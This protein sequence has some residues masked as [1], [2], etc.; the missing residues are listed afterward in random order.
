MKILQLTPYAMDRPGGVQTHVRDLSNWLR[1]RGHDVRI[2]APP[3]A[4]PVTGI[5]G[6]I[7][8]GTVRNIA[9]HGTK[10]E[11]TRARRAE[12]QACFAE[13]RVWGAEVAHLHTPW[14]PMLP[15]QVWRALGIPGVATFHATLPENQ[16][17]DPL[18]WA[19]RRSAHWFNKR[20]AGIAVPSQAPQDQW[21]ANKVDPLPQILPPTVDL[22]QWRAAGDDAVPSPRFSAVCMGRLEERKGTATLLSA[23][24]AVETQLPEA[25]LTIAGDGPCK[26]ALLEQ[27]RDLKL[28]NVT[29]APPPADA[30]ARALIAGADIFAA[31]A[32][33]G[34]SFGLVLIEAMAAGTLP[35]AAANEGY[36]TVMTGEGTDLLVPP[37]DAQALATKILDIATSAELKHRLGAWAKT[38]SDRFDVRHLGPA[39]EAFFQSALR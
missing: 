8:L 2:V 5:E 36:A 19:L 29:F 37:A 33:H 35:V 15:L 34:E 32:H 6:L 25:R 23:W 9:V 21:R 17:F 1:S 28:A 11:L 24:R 3:G 30:E 16:G 14:T 13:L 38:H 4:G 12:L 7:E 22:S 18:A 31:P 10:F 26:A 27:A 20:L 39:Y